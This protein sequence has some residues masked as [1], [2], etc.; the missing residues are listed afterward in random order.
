MNPPPAP[1]MV[2]KQPTAKPSIINSS[3]VI[4]NKTKEFNNF[5]YSFEII[6]NYGER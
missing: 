6:I 2:P 3:S 4:H 5:Y 1:T